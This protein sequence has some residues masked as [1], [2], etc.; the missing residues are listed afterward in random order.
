MNYVLR[1]LAM[2]REKTDKHILAA[3]MVDEQLRDQGPHFWLATIE[4][5]KLCQQGQTPSAFPLAP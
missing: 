2:G 1:A 4:S 3:G 5:Q